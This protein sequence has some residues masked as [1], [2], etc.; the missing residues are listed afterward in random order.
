MPV[1]ILT[2][3]NQHTAA[4]G[5]S[6][7]FS[8]ESGNLY[9]GYFANRYGEQWMPRELRSRHEMMRHLDPANAVTYHRI[10]DPRIRSSPQ[11]RQLKEEDGA[12]RSST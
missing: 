4:C 5:T 9:I 7:G 11:T 1:P 2:L 3:Y 6:P 12:W 8:N 10:L